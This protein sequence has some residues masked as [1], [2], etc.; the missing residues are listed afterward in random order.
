MDVSKSLA[1][2]DSSPAALP[3][4]MASGLP[5]RVVVVGAGFAGLRC[6][7]ALGG[8]PAF[9]VVLVDR[10][11]HR[12]DKTR[13]HEVVGA[14]RGIDLA[15]LLERTPIEFVQA[16]VLGIDRRDRRVA[17][18]GGPIPYDT[19]V[20]A[21]GGSVDDH[22]VRGVCEH[23]LSFNTTTD[24]TGFLRTLSMLRRCGERLVIVGGGPTGV[25][26]AAEAARALDPGRVVL[27][28]NAD[29]LLTGYTP[30]LA[31]YASFVL[32]RAGVRV[33]PRCKVVEVCDDGVVIAGGERI[34]GGAVLWCG[35]MRPSSLLAGAWLSE[36]GRP[37]AVSSF[38]ASEVDDHVYVIGDCARSG[39]VNSS[40]PSAQIA[41]QQ[42]DFVA[43]DLQRRRSGET[44]VPFVGSLLGEFTSLG[45]ADAI[46]TLRLGPVWLPL[47][48]PLAWVFKEAG[49][50]R[51]ALVVE[52]RRLS[53]AFANGRLR[54][55]GQRLRNQS[56]VAT[57]EPAVVQA[58]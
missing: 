1:A 47:I 34:V 15:S 16:E 30:A 43:R 51:H 6:A 24:G 8:D 14:G 9:D 32:R 17:T 13:L 2:S 33:R 45:P 44:R 50:L 48:G 40:R 26:A 22:G 27:V 21:L 42:G 58:A 41:V 5:H 36:Q 19:L 11:R 3:E 18:A 53:L 10:D 54:A 12:V 49:G 38:L 52:G 20:F 29:R 55:K 39:E 23:S 35:G 46:G 28:D 7:T 31:T 4:S 37:A 57:D 56:S 25:E